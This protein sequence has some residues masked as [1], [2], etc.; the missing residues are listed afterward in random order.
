MA[1]TTKMTIK[2]LNIFMLYLC[3]TKVW[4]DSGEF[5]ISSKRASSH[6]CQYEENKCKHGFCKE[7]EKINGKNY[8]CACPP[9]RT[10]L[11]CEKSMPDCLKCEPMARKECTGFN[12]GTAICI[13]LQYKNEKYDSPSICF[14]KRRKPWR[15]RDCKRGHHDC[16][17]GQECVNYAQDE[18]KMAMVCQCPVGN[19]RGANNCE[20]GHNYE[21]DIPGDAF[22][23]VDTNQYGPICMCKKY[24]RQGNEYG[25]CK[26][27]LVQPKL[28]EPLSDDG[29][30]SFSSNKCRHGTC[31]RTDKDKFICECHG[32]YHGKY[33]HFKTPYCS[34]CIKNQRVEC[35]GL[36]DGTAV[37]ICLEYYKTDKYAAPSLCFFLKAK[38]YRKDICRHNKNKCD[39]GQECV[40]YAQ[41]D[42]KMQVV[43]QCPV[44]R[45]RGMDCIEDYKSM[46]ITNVKPDCLY[47]E[48]FG[49]F[50]VCYKYGKT[51]KRP[52]FC[53]PE[54]TVHGAVVKPKGS[55]GPCAIN[56]NKCRRGVCIETEQYKG[57]NF[58][59]ACPNSY[60]GR[61]CH[62]DM[63]ECWRCKKEARRDCIGLPDGTAVC[64][65]LEM[66][67]NEKGNPPLICYFKKSAP[68]RQKDCKNNKYK[69]DQ[70]QECVNY[71]QKND[72]RLYMCQCPAG[73]KRGKRCQEDYQVDRPA[74]RFFCVDTMLYGPIC[75]CGKYGS[76]HYNKY[77]FCVPQLKESTGYRLVQN[78]KTTLLA[79]DS[80]CDGNHNICKEGVC[81]EVKGQDNTRFICSCPVGKTGRLCHHDMYKCYKCRKSALT[82]CI[83]LPDG[84]SVCVC[85][86]T[87]KAII[88]EEPA[89]C[90]YDKAKEHEQRSCN[91]GGHECDRNQKCVK[92]DRITCQCPAGR[93]R[94]KNCNEDYKDIEDTSCVD[95]QKYGPICVCER[96]GGGFSKFGF[97]KPNLIKKKVLGSDT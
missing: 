75:L 53:K 81:M 86:E 68:W 82:D 57:G 20:E 24:G 77:G 37:C 34:E 92:Y 1:M 89:I 62:H 60:T 26:P 25:F 56:E 49:P 39:P 73:K 87:P 55:G 61:L 94:G 58:I 50:C 14:F 66:N 41:D 32:S 96:Y 83:G 36:E 21:T 6:P 19:T 63:I 27:E 54:I 4:A 23:C 40:N 97:C 69:C 95:T 51:G 88:A 31:F 76:Y 91:W 80:P 18:N 85:V 28:I 93:K 46:K 8:L 2:I 44:G 64:V 90:Y 7:T 9:K 33:C 70:G 65:C 17:P 52:G 74:G 35:L 72:Y 16:T 45:T 12:D 38:P 42:N 84:R 59:C 30:C 78:A 15:Q 3:L 48:K 10:G 79:T 22:S 47:S 5:Y 13:C 29:P 43:C 71:A 11:L 67:P